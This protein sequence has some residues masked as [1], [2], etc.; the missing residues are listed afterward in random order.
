MSKPSDAIAASKIF[1]VE[2]AIAAGKSM[3]ITRI[4]AELTSRG[5][6]VCVIAEPVETWNECG[7]LQRFYADPIAGAYKF[8]TFAY[9]TRIMSIH[10][11]VTAN[12]SADVYLLERSPASDQIFMELQRDD[13][14]PV[15]M[16]MYASWC[17][18]FNLMLPF[19]LTRAK[20]LLL[21]TSLECCMARL[22]VRNRKGE[23]VDASDGDTGGG[24]SS[25]YQK[26]LIRAYD[27][28]FRV[29]RTVEFPLMPASPFAQENIINVEPELANKNFRDDGRE[30][31]AVI[32][33]IIIKMGWS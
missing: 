29:G 28:F 3:L 15:D 22:A 11:A 8:Q 24:V 18:S 26:R 12:P 13:L 19:D 10:T 20:V 14:D 5:L 31:D 1:V 4:A 27:S 21:D 23:I 25:Q 16:V 6:N 9:S 30:C 32:R 17:D 7:A 2:G 33:K